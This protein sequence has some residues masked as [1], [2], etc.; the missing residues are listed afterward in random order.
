M[1]T[2]PTQGM[3]CTLSMANDPP[4]HTDADTDADTQHKHTQTHSTNTHS[5]SI[6]TQ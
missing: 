6:G 1:Q 4:K 2:K 3:T 5:E